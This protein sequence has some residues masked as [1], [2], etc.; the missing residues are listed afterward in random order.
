MI[1]ST[2][3][4]QCN[5]PWWRR[6]LL[7]SLLELWRP[8]APSHQWAWPWGAGQ[9]WRLLAGAWWSQRRCA[10]VMM[11]EVQ[12]NASLMPIFCMSPKL[13]YYCRSYVL[14]SQEWAVLSSDLCQGKVQMS[15]IML[16]VRRYIDAKKI[17]KLKSTKK[18]EKKNLKIGCVVLNKVINNQI[19]DAI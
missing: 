11:N 9:L 15:S 17:V 14:Q 6:V 7:W 2:L 13:L 10:L 1:F 3:S 12:P 5:S 19:N 18:Y 8:L 16:N 4:M